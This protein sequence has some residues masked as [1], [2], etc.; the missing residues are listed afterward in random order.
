M[1]QDKLKTRR[2]SFGEAS[3]NYK[4]TTNEYIK[5]WNH[6][7]NKSLKDKSFRKK[8]KSGP[9]E[10]KV[11]IVADVRGPM[12]AFYMHHKSTPPTFHHDS[13]KRDA[14]RFSNEKWVPYKKK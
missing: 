8:S 9:S 4:P 14:P 10:S 6:I 2:R 12:P 5:G 7:F 1:H 13:R 3:R 11:P